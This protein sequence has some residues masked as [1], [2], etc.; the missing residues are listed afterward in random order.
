MYYCSSV[1]N[2]AG[3]E[4]SVGHWACPTC[5]SD[6]I[7]LP[8]VKMSDIRSQ[9]FA[10]QDGLCLTECPMENNMLSNISHL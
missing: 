10:Y 9:P 4:L 1:C 2:T 8:E 7:C 5:M 6:G 3:M